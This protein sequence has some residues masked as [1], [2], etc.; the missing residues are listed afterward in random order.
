MDLK[1]NEKEVL[2]VLSRVRL[3]DLRFNKVP[4]IKPESLGR[5]RRPNDSGKSG[6]VSCFLASPLV[7]RAETNLYICTQRNAIF[8]NSSV[9]IKVSNSI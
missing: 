7:L 1:L 6:L 8:V 9:R 5:L 2:S 3:R 4:N